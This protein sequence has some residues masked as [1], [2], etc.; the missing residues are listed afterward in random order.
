MAF[1]TPATWLT[2]H[3]EGVKKCHIWPQFTTAVAFTTL[4]FRD[5]ATYWKSI[6]FTRSDDECPSFRPR[7][8]AHPSPIFTENQNLQILALGAL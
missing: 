2:R 4:W 7:H 3:W 6:T 1:A 5:E 8:L